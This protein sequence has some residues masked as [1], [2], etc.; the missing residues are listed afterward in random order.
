MSGA[1]VAV[2]GAGLMGRWHASAASLTGAEIAAVVDVRLDAASA[3]AA[4]HGEASTYSDLESAL[5]AA[6]IDVVHVCTPTEEHAALV[7]IA[8]ERGCHALVEKPL[9]ESLAETEALLAQAQESG[10]AVNPVHQFPFQPGFRNV[11]ERRA[12]LGEL[13]RVSYRTCSAGG[14]GRPPEERRR[15]LLEIL[16]HPVSLL[17]HLVPLSSD[18]AEL[19]VVR[20]TEDDLDLVGTLGDTRLDVSIS[21]R[22]RPTRNE[23]EVVGGQASALVDLFHGYA[24]V[25][26]GRVSRSAKAL[27]P[28]ALGGQLVAKAGGNLASRA[29]RR[30]P[31]YPG[32]RELIRRF[33]AAALAGHEPPVPEAETLAAARLIDRVRAGR[34]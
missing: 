29:L 31:A 18:L 6:P 32:L 9:A 25:E 4:R 11:L 12:R 5:S 7:G 16:P 26:G 14:E 30:E 15:V 1:R 3:L 28:F 17:H 34:S 22:G 8:L 23:L 27:R 33:H 20:F 2:V 19:D 24:V 10:L 21:L 13:V